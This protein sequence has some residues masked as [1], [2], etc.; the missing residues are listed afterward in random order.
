MG[1]AQASTEYI[2]LLGVILVILIPS[3]FYSLSKASQE[4]KASQLEEIAGRIKQSANLVY[5]LGPGS[6]EIIFVNV[7]SNIQSIALQNKKEF[8][9]KMLSPLQSGVAAS[10]IGISTLPYLIGNIVN[11][12]GNHKLLVSSFNSTH[13]NITDFELIR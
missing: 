12:R 6:Q 8:V 4:I 13:V 9:I 10:D 5:T 1:K 7:P 11:T 2:F 3:V